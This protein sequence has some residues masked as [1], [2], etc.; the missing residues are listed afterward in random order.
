METHLPRREQALLLRPQLWLSIP[1]KHPR[2]GRVTIALVLRMQE[3]FALPRRVATVEPGVEGGQVDPDGAAGAL[4]SG[5]IASDGAGDA[6][7]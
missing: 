5:G 6:W 4:H 1:F 7:A 3:I 2:E